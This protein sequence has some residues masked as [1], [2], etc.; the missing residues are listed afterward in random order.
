MTLVA[1]SDGHK[2]VGHHAEDGFPV[3]P[4]DYTSLE[5]KCMRH[6]CILVLAFSSVAAAFAQDTPRAEVFGGYS[7]LHIDTQGVTGSTLD[8]L[9]NKPR[10]C[11]ERRS[12]LRLGRHH[13]E[14]RRK[15][16]S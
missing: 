6:V 5:G 10:R 2:E 15:R 12:W 9:C 3:E 8:A 16:E 14:F 13:F 4:P 1:H 7:Y 11:P